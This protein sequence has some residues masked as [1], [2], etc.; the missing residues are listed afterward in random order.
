MTNLA[1]IGHQD[2]NLYWFSMSVL[3][4]LNDILYLSIFVFG[5]NKER[6]NGA[7]DVV[8]DAIFS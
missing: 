5:G 8:D 3:F 2:L 4:T 1:K 7:L 6:K